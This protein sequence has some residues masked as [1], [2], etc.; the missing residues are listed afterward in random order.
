[1]TPL[2]GNDATTPEPASPD[3]GT[4]ERLL[5]RIATLLGI[6]VLAILLTFSYFASSLFL[7][8]V[9]ATFLAILLDPIVELLQRW[10]F[11]RSV[12]ATLVI[13]GALCL[14]ALGITITYNKAAIFA[15]DVPEYVAKLRHT[16]QPVIS[17]LQRFED[18][19]GKLKNETQPQKRVPEVKVQQAPQWPS[20]IARGVSSVSGALVIAAVVPVLMFFMLVRKEPMYARFESWLGNSIDFPNF[21]TKLSLMVRSYFTGNLIIGSGMAVCSVAVFLGLGL[22]GAVVL[23][24]VC[25]FVNLIPYL[26]LVLAIVIPVLAGLLQFTSIGP[27]MVIIAT[28]S[29][30][31]LVANNIAVPRF[32]GS[33]VDLGPV[34]ATAGILFWG[35][36]W[37]G[38]GLLLA[39]PLTAFIKLVAESHPSLR[40]VAEFLSESARP[41]PSWAQPGAAP[42]ARVQAYVRDSMRRRSGEKQRSAH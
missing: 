20:Y 12:G 37:G 18:T 2:S 16:V 39:I 13:F 30:L 24:L 1:V 15:E 19:A 25:G 38:I 26:G 17:K 11:P 21:V 10:H 8:L 41:V 36:L 34:A 4:P 33:R 40:L 28:E 42:W 23:G 27:F 31:H 5:R 35:W 7:T 6:I 32:I 22:Q 14:L 3:S 9:L 29:V